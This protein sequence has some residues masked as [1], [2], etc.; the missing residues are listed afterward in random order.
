MHTNKLPQ[1][2]KNKKERFRRFREFSASLFRLGTVS[3]PYKRINQSRDAL[4]TLKKPTQS[5]LNVFRPSW[6]DLSTFRASGSGSTKE[7]QAMNEKNQ[8]TN[9]S[10]EVLNTLNKGTN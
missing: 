1:M 2:N 5:N 10:R 7:T 4:N 3:C 8:K 6:S 9:Q